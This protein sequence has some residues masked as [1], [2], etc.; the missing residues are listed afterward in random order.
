MKALVLSGGAGRRLNPITLTHAKQLLPVA[1]QPILHYGLAAIQA[2][3]ISEV[4]V[5]VGDTGDEVRAALG[6]GSR[7]GLDITYIAQHAPLGL[8]HAVKIAEPFVGSD[9]FM[10]YLGDN[11]ITDQL[12]PLVRQFQAEPP[13]AQ[14]VLAHVEDAHEFGV[15]EI[16]ED[17]SILRVVEKP[18]HRVS[19]FALVGVYLFGR[20]I[21]EAV[22]AISPS[23][24]GELEIADA[25]QW[26]IDHSAVVRP[27][28]FEGWWK[29]TGSIE[30]LLE[31]NRVMLDL[32]DQTEN[33]GDSDEASRVLGRVCIGARTQLRNSVIYGPVV[34]GKDCTITDAAIGPYTSIH[35]GCQVAGCAVEHSILMPGCILE[36]VA[37]L[38]TD[39]LLGD[40]VIIRHAPKRDV[41]HRPTAG[42]SSALTGQ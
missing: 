37:G 36:G 22:N 42:D 21:F 5:V 40:N 14:I 4:G 23:A 31:A 12:E 35:D 25:I 27:H 13:D 3:G 32:M 28:F 1:N 26:L 7:W 29:D 8:A 17:G 18:A 16:A 34:I 15:A 41:P 30:N 20:R 19:N 24:R 10:M 9:S 33:A 6:D 39:S 38:V 11:L 2:S